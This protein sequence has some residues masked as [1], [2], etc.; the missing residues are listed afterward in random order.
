M[1]PGSGPELT[2][3]PPMAPEVGAERPPRVKPGW[4]PVMSSGL[5]LHLSSEALADQ[6]GLLGAEA[7]SLRQMAL[8]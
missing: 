1:Y 5:D 8:E 3:S 7:K 4:G 6:P 2:A